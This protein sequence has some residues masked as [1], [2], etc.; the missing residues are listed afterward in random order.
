MPVSV[1]PADTNSACVDVA[2]AAAAATAFRQSGCR[3]G[4]CIIALGHDPAVPIVSRVP[5]VDPLL[6]P[7]LTRSVPGLPCPAPR[8]PTLH[9]WCLS[10]MSRFSPL[11]P[12]GSP[13][14]MV[15]VD[16]VVVESPTSYD[17]PVVPLEISPVADHL[18]TLNPQE[19]QVSRL[20]SVQ[21]SPNRVCE[22]LYNTLD[23]F[24]MFTVSP[25][26]DGYLPCVSPVT[27]PSSPVPP[28]APLWA[29]CWMKRLVRL[30]ATE[31]GYVAV[32]C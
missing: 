8:C 1:R 15:S 11:N 16:Q 13:V 31:S 5:A 26:T 12:P 22:D 6:W 3:T 28:A 24:P 18:A 10:T 25:R 29:L 30:T 4:Y 9:Q 19:S 20:S 14:S 23:V 7:S 32:D 17:A 27:S 21:L 2:A